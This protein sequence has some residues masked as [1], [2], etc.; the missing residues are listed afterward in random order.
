MQVEF[1]IDLKS[2][3]DAFQL[4]PRWEI[5]RIV[6]QV[7]DKIRHDNSEAGILH[8]SNGNSCGRWWLNIEEDE[9]D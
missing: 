1:R 7:L 6:K 2:S 5:A 4:L 3:N 8:D 9:D